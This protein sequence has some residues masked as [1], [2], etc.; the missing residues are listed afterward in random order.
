MLA[1]SGMSGL[2]LDDASSRRNGSQQP[3]SSTSTQR[4]ELERLFVLSQTGLGNADLLRD[5]LVKAQPADVEGPLIQVR[6]QRRKVHD[7]IDSKYN[8]RNS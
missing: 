3:E 7:M 5:L 4:S 8:D 6:L 2:S 1:T